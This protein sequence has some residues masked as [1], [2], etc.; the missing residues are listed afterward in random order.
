[1][2]LSPMVESL[3]SFLLGLGNLRILITLTVVVV[4]TMAVMASSHQEAFL[5]SV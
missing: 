5:Q 4:E 1:M 3:L 2:L